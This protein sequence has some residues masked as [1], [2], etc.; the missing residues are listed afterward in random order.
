MINSKWVFGL[1]NLDEVMK[2]RKEVFH[3]EL[4]H[5]IYADNDD[6]T[7]LHVLISEDDKY[8]ACGRI[9]DD[10]GE[11]RIGMVCV[12]SC[13]RCKNLGA[14]VVKMLVFRGFELLAKKIF[15]NTRL[16][17]VGFYE[18]LNF[19]VCGEQFIDENGEKTIPMILLK[20]NFPFNRDCSGCSG[21]ENSDSCDGCG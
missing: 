13:V 11:F 10:N 15:V 7:A 4:G 18:K 21:C 19:Q 17:T 9:Y 8:Y 1:K 3:D 20:E 12:A 14:F 16:C 5:K 6:E 2:L